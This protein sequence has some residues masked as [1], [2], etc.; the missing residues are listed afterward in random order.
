MTYDQFSSCIEAC[1]QCANACDRCFSACFCE[2]H[3]PDMASC[4]RIHVDCAAICRTAA[5]AMA[6]S[7]LVAHIICEACARVCDICAN[8]S[9]K[10]DVEVCRQADQA[11]RNCATACRQAAALAVSTQVVN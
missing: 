2:Q 8:E 11:C 7:S 3:S 6:R 4:M 5:G 10:H 9:M 1:N